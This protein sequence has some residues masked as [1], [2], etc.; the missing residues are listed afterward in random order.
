M[1]D[2]VTI[3]MRR[4][5]AGISKNHLCRTA[6]IDRGTYSRLQKVKGSGRAETF[7]KLDKALK[8]IAERGGRS[9]G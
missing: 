2:I 4:K 6:A 9:D 1:A 8:A 5:A 7:D 3:E